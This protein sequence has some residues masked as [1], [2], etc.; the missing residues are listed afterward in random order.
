[1]RDKASL[2]KRLESY[3][4]QQQSDRPAL[5]ELPESLVMAL[6]FHDNMLEG[7]S[8]KPE[9]IQV[10]VQGRDTERPSYLRPLLEDIRL[11]RDA[12]D[13]VWGWAQ[14]GPEGLSNQ[15][16]KR[17]H[18]HL[19][20][21]E[22]K[23][24]ARVRLN[25]PVHR[26]YHQE[27]CSHDAVPRLLQE[28][29]RELNQFDPHTQDVLSYAAYLHHRLMYIYPFRRAPGTLARLIT[30]QFLIAHRYPPLLIPAHQRGAYYD[31]IASRD[32]QELTQ[33]FYQAMWRFIETLPT[34][35]SEA[36]AQA[37][38]GQRQRRA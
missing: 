23:E 21:Y 3:H 4:L 10:A 24:G 2:I 13:M 15:R 32:H 25:S 29:F 34:L 16:L 19:L 18:K 27:I 6:I 35:K 20:T 28:L 12:L 14:Q 9:D 22:P 31:A 36:H 33:L 30:N 8:F 17:L 7:R 26:D 37:Q 1:M 38:R 5:S 11:Y